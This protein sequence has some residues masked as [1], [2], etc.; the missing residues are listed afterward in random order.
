MPLTWCPSPRGVLAGVIF[1]AVMMIL[2]SPARP[3]GALLQADTADAVIDGQR[4]LVIWRQATVDVHVQLEVVGNASEAIWLLPV[5]GLPE[6]SGG[7]PDVFDDLERMT[8]PVVELQPPAVRDGDGC[9]G[10]ADPA[11]ASANDVSGGAVFSQGGTVGSYQYEIVVAPTATGVI[12]HLTEQGFAVPTSWEDEITRYVDDGMLFVAAKLDDPIHADVSALEP[13]VM[14]IAR[15]PTSQLVYP[16]GIGRLS[17]GEV[18]PILVYQL[19]DRR[20]RVANFASVALDHLAS[21]VRDNHHTDGDPTY[22]TALDQLTEASGGKLVVTE[23]AGDIRALELP[24]SLAAVVSDDSFYLTRTFLRPRRE[25]IDDLLLSFAS[26]GPDED[27]YA[28]APATSTSGAPMLV[29]VMLMLIVFRRA[30]AIRTPRPG[31]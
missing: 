29:L 12:D 11:G 25:H 2:T 26:D 1:A 3:C 15:P 28:E 24:P 16:A 13:L 10:A 7:D 18:I 27:G 30:R 4:A 20:Y 22:A 17:G 14:T 21:R 31:Q 6:L 19:S 9:D 8:T 23:F 5:S